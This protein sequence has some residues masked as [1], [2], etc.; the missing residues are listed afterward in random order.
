MGKVGGE[1]SN[2]IGFPHLSETTSAAEQNLFHGFQSQPSFLL[3]LFLFFFLSIFR[4]ETLQ[5]KSRKPQDIWRRN[6]DEFHIGHLLYWI[7]RSWL[8]VLTQLQSHPPLP[9]VP[10]NCKILFSRGNVVPFPVGEGDSQK[11]IFLLTLTFLTLEMGRA[12]CTWAKEVRLKPRGNGVISYGTYW[13]RIHPL[14]V[15]HP[16]SLCAA[17]T[18]H[19]RWLVLRLP[20]VPVSPDVLCV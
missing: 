6:K 17:A 18:S 5:I 12:M 14:W 10:G 9:F 7:K 15:L 13:P 11:G 16:L 20:D 1:W 19:S 2:Y 8:P 4:A 3:F